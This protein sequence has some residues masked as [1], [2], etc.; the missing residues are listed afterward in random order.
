MQSA[1]SEP[2]PT[3]VLIRLRRVPQGTR[4]FPHPSHD[5]Q[6]P[7]PSNVAQP[8]YAQT[9]CRARAQ[10]NLLHLSTPAPRRPPPDLSSPH[11]TTPPQGLGHP[12]VA[13]SARL[14]LPESAQHVWGPGIPS[15]LWIPPSPPHRK[16]PGPPAWIHLRQESTGPLPVLRPHCG[17]IWRRDPR[18]EPVSGYLH[19]LHTES[20]QVR[21][22]G[23][24][25]ARRAQDHY[26]S[27]G[28]TADQFGGEIQ[29]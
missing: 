4:L 11:P 21:P 19:H 9:P 18:I 16:L 3:S 24:T 6:S 15:R 29:G 12:Q 7:H 26:P 28:H 1:T 20:F 10:A 25:C 22:P 23:S 17:P 5:P 2:P 14:S 13:H 8:P 27:F